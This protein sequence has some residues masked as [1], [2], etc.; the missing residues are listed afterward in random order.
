[1]CCCIACL[2]CLNSSLNNSTYNKTDSSFSYTT[3][4]SYIHNGKRYNITNNANFYSKIG[5]A[6][7]YGDSF[8]G[9][10]TSSSETFDKH[11]LTTASP[12]LPLLSYVKV[13]NLAN[14]KQVV[15]KVNDR[16]PFVNN[17]I[18]DLSYAAAKKLDFTHKGLA[19]V[20]VEIIKPSNINNIALAKNTKKN[21]LA[22]KNSLYKKFASNFTSNINID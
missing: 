2:F 12:E 8:H 16:G 22:L 4:K 18:L 13:T 1:M 6:S 10:I 17:R 15:V 20:K 5:T 19:K 9:K 21:Q 11:K 7:W 3:A 14:G